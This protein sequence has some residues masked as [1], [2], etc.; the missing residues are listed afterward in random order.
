MTRSDSWGYTPRPTKRK[1][2][3]CACKYPHPVYIAK[4]AYDG[5]RMEF[6][7]EYVQ[8]DT[9]YC[10][11]CGGRRKEKARNANDV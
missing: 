11:W 10:P 2:R 7:G 3:P 8:Y 4:K 9:P 5:H 1:E 6:T